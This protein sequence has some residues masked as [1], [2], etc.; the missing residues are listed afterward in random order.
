[1]SKGGGVVWTEHRIT[2]RH[3][4]EG[5]VEAV[6]G[7]ARDISRQVET[8][9]RLESFNRELERRVA[10]RTADLEHSTR[11]MEEFCR[12]I[13]HNFRG[14]LRSINS[15]AH[16][17]GTDCLQ[18]AGNPHCR[19]ALERIRRI[20]TH[21]DGLM[22]SLLEL[23]R[24]S[25]T[26]FSPEVIDL[27]ALCRRL[28]AS[29]TGGTP[30]REALFTIAEG[31]TVTADPVQMERLMG[32]LLENAWKFTAPKPLAVI[33]IQQSFSAD[34]TVIMVRDNGVGFDMAHAGNL[35]RTFR[36]LHR[37]DEFAGDGMGLAIARCIVERH[38]G[39][40]RAEGEPGAG[41]GIYI[42]LP[43]SPP[44]AP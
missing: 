12:S 16:L 43:L 13:A 17:L 22:D 4:Q 36:R 21:M 24:V 23:G 40:I 18:A 6:D 15:N 5:R 11:E 14:P 2:P 26:S 38:G 42:T 9:R 31:M 1:M 35:F 32:L 37:H 3:D 29:L 41:A 28:A 30:E 33:E 19:A 7:I 27:T 44:H 20:T 8:T 39:S 34:E 10:E 25:R